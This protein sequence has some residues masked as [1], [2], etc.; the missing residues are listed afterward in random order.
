MTALLKLRVSVA[1][2]PVGLD[3]RFRVLV[4]SDKS[5]VSMGRVLANQIS[6]GLLGILLENEVRS[7]FMAGL[8]N[9][10]IMGLNGP[11]ALLNAS[12]C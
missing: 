12:T 2:L 6:S 11:K 7:R 3:V 5:A 8:Q 1:P 10:I 9:E 4:D